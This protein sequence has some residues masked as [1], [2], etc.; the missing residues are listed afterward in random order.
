MIKAILFVGA[1]GFVGSVFRYLV[2]LFISKHFVSPFPWPTFAV[3]IVGCLLIGM[4][5]ALADRGQVMTPELR[6][7]LVTG[8]CGGFTTFS[9]FAFDN[10]NLL[11]QGYVFHAFLYILVSVV[12]G[13]LFAYLGVF[14]IKIF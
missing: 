4:L 2:Q 12:L 13:I 8:F 5:Y 1:G 6:L 3:N 11:Q 10:V 14:L 9:S 7:L